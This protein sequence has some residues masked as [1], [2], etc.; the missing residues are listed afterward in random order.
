MECS[1]T[2]S[3]R[4]IAALGAIDAPVLREQ[5]VDIE[6]VARRVIRH[7]SEKPLTASR[8]KTSRTS[9]SRGILPLPT[10]HPSIASSF[11]ALRPN[12]EADLAHRDHGALDGC[13]RL[14]LAS[15]IFCEAISSGHDVLLDR[16][17]VSSFSTPPETL[18]EYGKIELRKVEVAERLELIRI[19]L[20]DQR[21]GPPHHSLRKH[22]DC[23]ENSMTSRAAARRSRALSNR[24]SLFESGQASR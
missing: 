19:S 5:V 4:S 13:L 17:A 8:R 23:P 10:R 12:R 18:Q 3:P 11:W 16:Y 1:S 15:T 14:S 24:I 9:S 6:D 20:D 7:M 2:R 22:R 21:Q